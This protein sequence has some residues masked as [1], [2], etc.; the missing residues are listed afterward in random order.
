VEEWAGIR[1]RYRGERQSIGAIARE[2]GLSRN[3][4]RAAVHSDQPPRYVRESRGSIADA[5]EPDIP[6]VERRTNYEAA[7][8]ARRTRGL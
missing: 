5:I 2:L 3:T 8:R 1:R 6:H 4:V 7:A